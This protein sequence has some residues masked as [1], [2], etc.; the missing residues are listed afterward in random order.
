MFVKGN[1]SAEETLLK[2]GITDDKNYLKNESN[3]DQLNR[4]KLGVF[5]LHYLIG[6][7]CD[8]PCKLAR[9]APPWLA[10][11]NL[12][13]LEKMSL[14]AGNVFKNNKIKTVK[15]L[16][17]WSQN[18]LCELRGFGIKSLRD[19]I[20]SLNVALVRG[21]PNSLNRNENSSSIQ[22]YLKTEQNSVSL[23]TSESNFSRLYTQLDRIPQTLS[24]VTP[25]ISSVSGYGDWL[26]SF[27]GENPSDEEALLEAGITDEQ[28]YQKF[29]LN[30]ER[31]IRH[32]LGLFRAH[33]LV[34]S[35]CDDLCAL[36]RAA[37]PWLAER[38]FNTLD[39]ITVRSEKVFRKEGIKTVQDLAKWSQNALLDL[40]NFGVKSLRDTIEALNA[41]LIKGPIYFV[42]YETIPKSNRLLTEFRQSL[43]SF[44]KR[45]R[46]ILTQRLGFE[47]EPKTLQEL[48]H[49][50][51]LTRERVR[52][53]EKTAT[54]KL[55]RISYWDDVLEQRIAQ[56]IIG[57]YYPLPVAGVEAID[58]WF[59]GISS[60]VGFFRK[61]VQT[62]CK[63]RIHI[64]EIDSIHYLSLID[65]KFW[66]QMV[67]EAASLLSSGA[68]QK[69]NES[70]ARSIINGLLPDNVKEFGQL[71]WD[72]V[73]KLCNFSSNPDGSRTLISYGRRAEQIVE[74]ILIEATKPLHYKEIAECASRMGKNLDLKK[75]HAAA[76]NVGFL[77]APGTYGLKR[78]LP[79][80]EEQM[81]RIC[82]E[83]EKIVLSDASNK[84]WHTSEILS[85]LSERL[86]KSFDGLE[87]Y[88]LNIALKKSE[89]ICALGRMIWTPARRGAEDQT[90]IDIRQA[91]ISLVKA[92]GRP[93]DANEIKQ[94]LASV[95]GVSEFF[96]ISPIDPLIK[97]QPGVWGIKGRDVPLS[98]E[99]H[100]AVRTG[101]SG[102]RVRQS[103][104]KAIKSGIGAN[105]LSKQEKILE[106]T[107]CRIWG[108]KAKAVP[109]RVVQGMPCRIRTKRGKVRTGCVL[110][111]TRSN[112]GVVEFVYEP[113]KLATTNEQTVLEGMPFG[114]WGGQAEIGPNRKVE[115]GMQCR[116]TTMRG[117]IRKGR[118]LA[119]TSRNS[120]IVQFVYQKDGVIKGRR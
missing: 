80:S 1:P 15:D 64:V 45:E 31:T 119:V 32:R 107:P 103:A 16:S 99:E 95:R 94:Q 20:E 46:D 97:V 98:R 102:K 24:R 81:F 82:M 27:F 49:D 30:L 88:V 50:Y 58:H 51:K 90:R 78:H 52:Q 104:T 61:L 65:Q 62:V 77:F 105:Q 35:A 29:E 83:A 6:R 113:S 84:Q 79:F 66:E 115:P 63:D 38:E 74:A 23:S 70:H 72:K 21:P 53:I 9:A 87:K 116:I 40:Q 69:W 33:Y 18:A 7:N 108:G 91:V 56:L 48:A 34:G 110:A 13:T 4:H 106:G 68:T 37:P 47:T 114:I 5:R 14:R 85:K 54:K 57:R 100:Q 26:T 101:Q 71:L 75:A 109:H 86:D 59:E 39:K 8:N 55:I 19:T 42:N 44:P 43:L 22:P 92:A 111:V 2:A 36:A 12:I 67:S 3:L 112:D 73:S 118:V 117:R 89:L 120:R 60:H 25:E 10:E 96:Q 11:R 76:V 17:K 93:L 41:A 28:T